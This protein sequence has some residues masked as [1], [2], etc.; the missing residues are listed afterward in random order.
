MGSQAVNIIPRPNVHL[1]HARLEPGFSGSLLASNCR[2]AFFNETFAHLLGAESNSSF[3]CLKNRGRA[4]GPRGSFRVRGKGLELRQSPSRLGFS[5]DRAFS[6]GSLQHLDLFLKSVFMW[7][8]EYVF[9]IGMRV[10][11][12]SIDITTGFRWLSVFGCRR[13]LWFFFLFLYICFLRVL[14][15]VGWRLFIESVLRF[16][17]VPFPWLSRQLWIFSEKTQW[18]LELYPLF[19][20]AAIFWV[21]SK[22]LSNL[23]KKCPWFWRNIALRCANKLLSSFQLSLHHPQKEKWE[24]VLQI[25]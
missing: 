21:F 14:I 7:W 16:Y 19:F 20:A 23:D 12:S 11:A 4:F 13:F 2:I 1:E 24:M 22:S 17:G 8:F 6:G 10:Y 25:Y 9:G 18:S 3:P 15:D 5:W